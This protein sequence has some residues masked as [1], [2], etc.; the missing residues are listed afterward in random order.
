MIRKLI[1]AMGATLMKWGAQLHRSGDNGGFCYQRTPKGWYFIAGSDPTAAI[2]RAME[3][4]G[5]DA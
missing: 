3:A 1:E 2:L 5:R 4:E